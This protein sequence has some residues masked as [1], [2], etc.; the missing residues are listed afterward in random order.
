MHSKRYR[1]ISKFF[2]SNDNGFIDHVKY[3]NLVL[4]TDFFIGLGWLV[5][6]KHWKNEWERIWP[7]NRKKSKIKN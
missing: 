6:A 7:M 3:D 2:F 1:E 5:S 4:K